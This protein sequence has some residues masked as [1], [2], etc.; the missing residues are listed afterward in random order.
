MT[1]NCKIICKFI[2]LAMEEYLVIRRLY[3]I[4]FSGIVGIRLRFAMEY[5]S[6]NVSLTKKKKENEY[7]EYFRS[8]F[9]MRINYL[10]DNWYN[11]EGE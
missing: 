3:I 4:S 7:L 8:Y 9:A 1:L 11:P 6:E 5:S 10:R 2:R